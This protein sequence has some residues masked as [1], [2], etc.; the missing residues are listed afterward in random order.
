MDGSWRE[1]SFMVTGITRAEAVRIAAEFGQLAVF[2]LHDEKM[3]VIEVATGEPR[4]AVARRRQ[5]T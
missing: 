3:L 1:E 2:E 4:R 5:R